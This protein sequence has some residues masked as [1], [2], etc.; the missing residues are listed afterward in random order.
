MSVYVILIFDI[1]RSDSLDTQE[2]KFQNHTHLMTSKHF[3]K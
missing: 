1:V 2:R 3:T